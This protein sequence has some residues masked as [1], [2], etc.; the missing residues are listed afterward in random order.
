M[1]IQ[2]NKRIAVSKEVHKYIMNEILESENYK[3]V[4]DYLREKLNIK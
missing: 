2:K 3:N 1:K 4:D